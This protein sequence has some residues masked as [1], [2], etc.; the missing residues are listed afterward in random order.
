MID[1]KYLQNGVDRI[2]ELQPVSSLYTAILYLSSRHVLIPTDKTTCGLSMSRDVG[3]E[4]THRTLHE[5]VM[6]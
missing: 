5:K 6:Y 2:G 1:F 3:I 4:V